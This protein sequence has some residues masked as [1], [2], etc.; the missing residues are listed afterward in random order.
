MKFY[1]ALCSAF[2]FFLTISLFVVGYRAGG[3]SFTI[4]GK[5]TFWPN[6]NWF[7]LYPAEFC[8]EFLAHTA[9]VSAISMQ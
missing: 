2:R 6:T 5:F 9:Q 4:E 7:G 1:L 8:N 3:A